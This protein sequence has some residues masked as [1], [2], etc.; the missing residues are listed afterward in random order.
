VL[1]S[2]GV[3]MGDVDLVREVLDLLGEMRWMQVAIKPAKPFAFGLVDGVPVF[4]LPGNPVSSLVAAE[5]FV[6]PALRALQGEADPSPRFEAGELTAALRRAEG[7]DDLVRA[8]AR[9]DAD[10]VVRLEPLSGQE[11]HMIARAAAATALVL[12]PRGAGE[13]P[14][15]SAVRYLRL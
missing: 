8:L 11:S 9:L 6:R 10:G 12:V 4:G 1:T 5:L 7:R 2:G 13:L 14:A 15:G 3:S